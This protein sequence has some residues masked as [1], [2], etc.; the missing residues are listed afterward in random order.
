MP[1]SRSVTPSAGAIAASDPL[2]DAVCNG[3]ADAAVWAEAGAEP[4]AAKAAAANE[5]AAALMIVFMDAF[6]TRGGVFSEDVIRTWIE[7]KRANEVDV[8]RLRPHPAEFVL[9]Y[10]A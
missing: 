5:N 2:A 8:V 9:Y 10:D 1:T 7:Y 6:L 3:A 4:A